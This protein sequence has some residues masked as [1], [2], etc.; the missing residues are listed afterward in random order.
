MKSPQPLQT[1]L[2][3]LCLEQE[4][5][6]QGMEIHLTLHDLADPRLALH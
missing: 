4:P 3:W 6:E 2:L 5:G 1:S